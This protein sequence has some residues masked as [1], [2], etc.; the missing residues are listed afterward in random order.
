M[1]VVG[2]LTNDG[3]LIINGEIDERSP[4]VTSG[5][6]A[7][8]PFDGT[9]KKY[10]PSKIRYI[11]DWLNGS[12]AN[13]GNHWVEI[14]AFDYERKNI[15]SGKTGTSSTGV[16]NALLTNDVITSDP[17]WGLGAGLSWVSIDLGDLYNIQQIKVW[18]YYAD[19]R[20]YKETKTEVSSD[21]VNWFSIFDSAIEGVYPETSKGKTHNMLNLGATI[22][23]T[24]NTN[25]TLTSDG[26]AVD[27]ASKN[28]ILPTRNGEDGVNRWGRDTAGV[29]FSTVEDIR[30]AK[31]GKYV[32][33]LSKEP[34]TGTS[35]AYIN[36]AMFS[37]TE[38][39]VWTF[40]CYVKRADGKTVTSIGSVYLYCTGL[41][42]WV[43]P[44]DYIE[45]CGDGWYRVVK[46]R[47]GIDIPR[48]LN[49]VGFSGLDATTDWYFDG[50]QVE[51]LP[52]ATS[53]M[54]DSRGEGRIDIPFSLKPP[55]SINIWHTAVK[56]LS[57][58]TDQ[59]TS[60]MIFQLNGYH[61]NAS[62]SFWNFIKNL[63]IYIKGDTGTGWSTS[64]TYENYTADSWDNIE[65][66]YTLIAVNNRTFKVY[67]DGVYL[68][69]QVS[70]V[71]VTNISYL[72]MGNTS[73]PNAKYRDLSMYD[74]VINDSEVSK[75]Y[76]QSMSL[77]KDG[78][79]KKSKISEKPSGIPKD[80]IHIPLDFDGTDRLKLVKPSSETNLVYEKGAVWVGNATTNL[81]S[82][83]Q[84]SNLT[85]WVL[86]N[87]TD[88]NRT[89]TNPIGAQAK[90][91]SVQ[92]EGYAYI[93]PT[94][95]VGQLYTAS[96]YVCPSHDYTF[97]LRFGN[98]IADN[99]SIFAPKNT[100][101]RLVNTK[102]INDV[103][104]LIGYR[105]SDGSSNPPI[106]FEVAYSM[107]Q[108]EKSQFLTP[109]TPST[110]NTP[111]L[112]YN[113]SHLTNNNWKEFSFMMNVKYATSDVWRLCG[114]W[115]RWYFGPNP[116]N[117]LV[118]SF[119]DGTQ[120]SVATSGYTIPKDKWVT[121]AVT[122][123]NNESIDIYY[124]GNRVGGRGGGFNFTSASNDFYL[125][126]LN[127]VGSSYPIN[128]YVKDMVFADR[129]LTPKEISDFSKTNMSDKSG[130]LTI[131]NQIIESGNL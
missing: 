74:R 115:S 59:P 47:S 89:M 52:Y 5:L 8:F 32:T 18:H 24:V 83:N 131:N 70:T 117:S 2:R 42:S 69:E 82:S 64:K 126:G 3:S 93:D 16:W 84:Q 23:P 72:S 66:M 75:L 103:R 41:A 1:A 6:V 102:T 36:G 125:N 116:S 21:G 31:F 90:I 54:N 20:T 34:K 128:A 73:Q 79:L 71:D 25:T 17:Y 78:N 28:H 129:V 96:V 120:L 27:R 26:I 99:V 105:D 104:V 7:H 4:A 124:N 107:T 12:S 39:N 49:L 87:H 127:N 113:G 106:G 53:Y 19:A 123:K 13:T 15:T 122:V 35:N 29:V 97:R 111:I 46:T 119:M 109:Y 68:G 58:I 61:T 44:P 11:R 100:W 62:I 108:I 51:A 57:E 37:N 63:T 81:V 30:L 110:R 85:G 65:H 10:I 45:D 76:N 48:T 9:D 101:T 88:T 80:S 130:I 92:D 50:W 40:S 67:M 95:T 112:N 33:K 94:L 60:P 91:W 56:P 14:Q 98:Q 38:S 43:Q 118:F 77:S 22:S 86:A 114:A 55:Y 121:I